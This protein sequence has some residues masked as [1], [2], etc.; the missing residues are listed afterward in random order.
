MNYNTC[1][2]FNFEFNYNFNTFS[3][4]YDLEENKYALIIDPWTDKYYTEKYFITTN[5]YLNFGE[6]THPSPFEETPVST[7]IIKL[8]LDNK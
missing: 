6:S 4:I 1:S 3:I 7:E 8:D 5:F 2:N